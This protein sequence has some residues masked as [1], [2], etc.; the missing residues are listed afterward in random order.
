MF[1]W[2]LS[3]QKWGILTLFYA[4]LY[5]FFAIL[6]TF[7]SVFLRKLRN[8][9][10][11]YCAVGVHIVLLASLL[12]LVLLLA[13]L[14]YFWHPCCCGWGLHAAVGTVMFLLSLLLLAS[15]P[16]VVTLFLQASLLL[17]ASILCWRPC[18][19]FHSCSCL[20]SCCC[21]RS[22]YCCHP[23]YYLL[24]VTYS[25]FGQFF[26]MPECWT[27]LYRNKGTPIRYQ[28][29]AKIFVVQIPQNSAEFEAI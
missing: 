5:E 20:R 2:N 22:W 12:M 26:K 3:D 15:L 23:S 8:C 10:C 1:F 29:L 27:F 25:I 14:Y 17:M 11:L 28:N 16:A 13:S 6:T 9:L 21:E 4:F 19:R 24:L 7:F 18:C